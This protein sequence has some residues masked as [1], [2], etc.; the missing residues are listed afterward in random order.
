MSLPV[1]PVATPV[2]PLQV[3]PI[4]EYDRG[5]LLSSVH[6]RAARQMLVQS[7]LCGPAVAMSLAVLSS[8]VVAVLLHA[9]VFVWLVLVSVRVGIS[10]RSVPATH[11]QAGSPSPAADLADR[12]ALFCLLILTL[13]PTVWLAGGFREPS[14]PAFVTLAATF[15]GLAVTSWRHIPMYR[16]LSE[17]SHAIHAPKLA[18]RLRWLGGTKA[19]IETIWLAACSATLFAAG[20]ANPDVAVLIAFVA[21]FGVFA[22]GVLW[23]WMIVEH[24]ILASRIRLMAAREPDADR[25]ST[26][27]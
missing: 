17:W 6:L 26:S 4:V 1:H 20:V 12:V 14:V 18:R 3:I 27:A 25:A 15:F 23:V 7:V 22:F 19:V 16:R 9:A 8:N 21:L 11:L 2:A 5:G 10:L 24:A 13:A